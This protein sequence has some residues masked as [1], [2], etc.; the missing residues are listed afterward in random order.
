MGKFVIAKQLAG[1]RIITNDGEDLGKLVDITVNESSGKLESLL[2][3]PNL[4]NP[5]ARKLKREEGLA[6][7]PYEAVL[8]ASDHMII[9]KKHVG[10]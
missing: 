3:E 6:R 5:T 1:K 9:D 2:F 4:D 10:Y 8:A 7:V